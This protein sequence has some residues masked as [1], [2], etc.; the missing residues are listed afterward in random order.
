MNFVYDHDCGILKGVIVLIAPQSSLY[1]LTSVGVPPN[2]L[3]GVVLSNPLMMVTELAPLGSLLD[4]L[5]KQLTHVS[6]TSKYICCLLGLL[7]LVQKSFFDVHPFS[8]Y[9]WGRWFSQ[10]APPIF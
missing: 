2:R 3:Y 10:M 4:Y 6:I 1:I 9:Y 7:F 8:T 5:R